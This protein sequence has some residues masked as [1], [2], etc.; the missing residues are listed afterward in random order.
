MSGVLRLPAEELAERRKKVKAL[1]DYGLT[2]A[3][4]SRRLGMARTLVYYDIG[5]IRKDK[6][7]KGTES[8]RRNF[9]K[10]A[11][12]ASPQ[13]AVSPRAS[14]QGRTLPRARKK[15]DFFSFLRE[16]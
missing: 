11:K 6:G 4:I 10:G 12:R 8:A 5:V 7:A 14:R 13:S 15:P 9:A 2:A 3:E 1:S 16:K